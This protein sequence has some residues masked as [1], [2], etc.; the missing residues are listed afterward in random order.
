MIRMALEPETCVRGLSFDLPGRT[1]TVWHDPGRAADIAGRLGP[2]G[3]GAELVGTRTDSAPGAPSALEAA[4]GDAAERRMLWAV[5][6]INAGMFVAELVAGLLVQSTG[7]ISDS[8]DM[9][10]DALVYGLSLYAVGRAA[11]H[12]LRAARASGY[13][14][15]I[16]ALGALAEVARRS[17]AGSDPRPTW[18]FGVAAVALTANATVLVLVSRHRHRGAHIKAS[19]IFSTNDVLANLGVIAA[20]GLVAWTNSPWPDLVVGAAIGLLVLAGSVRILRLR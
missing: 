7:L 1:L 14:Q 15:L 16:L 13:L 6:A 17:I 2:L 19:Y 10:A 4:A 11:S 5:L 9:L 20:G 8:L 12:K 18:M 3:L